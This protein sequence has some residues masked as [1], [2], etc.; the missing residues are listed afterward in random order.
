MDPRNVVTVPDASADDAETPTRLG[1]FEIVSRLG[2]G[3]MGMVFE[4]RD[5]V[6]GRRVA[7]KLLHPAGAKNQVA[8]ARLLR[9]AQALAK[10]AHP[11]V[12]TVFEVGMAGADPFIAMELVEGSTLLDWI[13]DGHDWRAVL[14][15]FIAVGRGLAAVHALG[16]V[17]R[18]FK[19][20]NVLFDTRGV[21]KLGDFGLVGALEPGA[22]TN[23]SPITGLLGSALTHE[24]AYL[25]T[26]RYMAP[27]QQA[28]TPATP[29]SDQYSFCVSLWEAV[30]G[31]HPFPQP[32][33][34]KS[35]PAKST[36]KAP[37]WLVR[38]L[39]QGLAFAP[40]RRHPSM[41]ALLD[42][43]E[44]A[45]KIRRRAWMAAAAFA[46]VAAGSLLALRARSTADP[47]DRIAPLEAWTP[48][49]RVAT[50]NAFIATALPFAAQAHDDVA[51]QLDDYATRWHAMKVQSCR[52][53]ESAE[54]H[55]RR[56]L[57]LARRQDE[58]G[59][60]VAQLRLIPADRV[61][62][63]SDAIGTLGDLRACADVE[64][65]S[66]IVPLPQDPVRAEQVRTI[67]RDLA[68]VEAQHAIGR[69]EDR[70]A[71]V[72]NL[73][74]VARARQYP[75]V[76]VRALALKT[77]LAG[78]R[79]GW[80][81]VVKLAN[82]QLVVAEA[83]GDDRARFRIYTLLLSV[84]AAR[85]QKY[86][87]ATQAGQLAEALLQRLGDD[88]DLAAQL[89][90]AQAHAEWYRGNY[91]ESLAFANRCV[92]ERERV[93]PRN[94]GAI[95][96]A[97]HRKATVEVALKRF[98]A[99]LESSKRSLELLSHAY[100]DQHPTVA[101]A[102][103]LQGLI[104][105]NLGHDDQA[106]PLYRRAIAILEASRGQSSEL[107]G[108]LMNLGT[109]LM[110]HDKFTD[111]VAVYRRV[112][113]IQERSVGPNNNR[114]ANILDMLGKALTRMGDFK[115]GE[116]MSLRS[117]KIRETN[118]AGNHPMQAT[119]WRIL[120]GNYQFAKQWDKA[121]DA[122]THSLQI[123]EAKYGPKSPL[124]V[125]SLL[126]IAESQLRAEHPERARPILERAWT[127]VEA[128]EVRSDKAR[129]EFLYAQALWP[130]DEARAR[131]LADAAD[132]DVRADEDPDPALVPQI[133][134]WRK[135]HDAR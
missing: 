135:A 42:E 18:D 86:D 46:V 105:H 63:A 60:V 25:G 93:V 66:R 128:P 44:R 113:A 126:G 65:L 62:K 54:I 84:N 92:A 73:V 99:A 131:K 10:L 48:E 36:R 124:L 94:E 24:G 32:Q 59:A 41:T 89:H 77:E 108:A 61:E 125:T 133:E 111:A 33:T 118:G 107:G 130:S 109:L 35:V 97:V 38:A 11:N 117:I 47:C 12:V 40:E 102:V 70:S 53:R 55:V 101:R 7:I 49:A 28:R 110:N 15:V 79:D 91:V 6:L 74:A 116:E 69:P 82:E 76:L 75:P 104:L 123:L 96:D 1:H 57:C 80:Q 56:N 132:E 72:E 14:D 122:Y 100:G 9:E 83:A 98:D 67:E 23:P 5:A 120:G 134:A 68:A 21:P 103:N 121:S 64:A 95:G 51:R 26:P 119:A 22:D 19:P 4:A 58:V 106:E 112:L 29:K 71:K 17:H 115:E 3:G 50:R 27:E 34:E 114:L 127:H 20:S 129:L 8:P 43:L 30:F 90:C 39:A 31:I 52:T 16:L 37:R 78:D 88:P 81:D 13:R 87:D 45:P 2:A 85:L